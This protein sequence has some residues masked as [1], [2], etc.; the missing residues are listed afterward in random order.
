VAGSPVGRFGVG[1]LGGHGRAVGPAGPDPDASRYCDGSGRHRPASRANATVERP[2]TAAL[3]RPA[4][5][6][7]D[8]ERRASSTGRS[9]V[10]S[11]AVGRSPSRRSPVIGVEHFPARGRGGD[12]AL[13][14]SPPPSV[15]RLRAWAST[16]A[17]G[18]ARAAWPRSFRRSRRSSRHQAVAKRPAKSPGRSRPLP[19]RSSEPRSPSCHQVWE[20][21]PAMG[22]VRTLNWTLN[23]ESRPQRE[24]IAVKSRDVV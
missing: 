22:T 7:S 18:V 6:A 24:R 15:I 16:E 19:R 9:E 5:V 21:Y 14:P 4:V 8:R 3:A 2:R 11:A 1:P 23:A 12:V 20:L 10:G 17:A 13:S